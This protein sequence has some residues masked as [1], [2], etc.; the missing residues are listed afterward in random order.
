MTGNQDNLDACRYSS[1]APGAS[2]VCRFGKHTVTLDDQQRGEYVPNLKVSA[3]T[4]SG[5]TVGAEGSGTPVPVAAPRADS[6]PAVVPSLRQ[7]DAGHG[8]PWS[9]A[10]GTRVVSGPR[11]AATAR[12]FVEDL[13]TMTGR[14][15]PVV[16]EPARPGDIVLSAESPDPALGAEEYRLSIG[17]TVRIDA[18]TDTGAFYGT[19]TV[20]QMLKA[21]PLRRSL[22][23]GT[24]QD[25]PK[26]AT[27][28]QMLDVGRKFFPVSYLK[29]QIRQ[30]AWQKLNVFHLHFT[31]W[32][33]FRIQSDTF[34]GLTPKDGAY[35]K[36]DL[37]ALQDYAAK[38]HVEIVPEVDLPG[39][40]TPITSYDP[41]LR[42][43]CPS[44]D[45]AIWPGG[46]L[47][48]WTL[49]ITKPHTREFVKR[50]LDEIVPLFDS[51][52][53]H[54]GGDEIGYDDK[55]NAC[56]ELVQYA[57][58]RGFTYTG[59]VFVDFANELNATVR[60][61][62][63]TT[64]MWEWWNVYGQK[65]SISP[66]KNIIVDS[67]VSSD[68]SALAAQGYRVVATPENL[69]YVS[70]GFGQRLGQYGYVDVRKVYEDY[71]FPAP[72]GV[73]G[74]RVSRWS[75]KAEEQSPEWFDFY[76]KRPL[77]VLAERTWGGPRS[78][79]VWEFFARADAIG[80]P[81][82]TAGGELTAV[83]TNA[84]R[85]TTDSQETSQENGAAVNVLDS[86]PYTTWHTA[87][88]PTEVPM[89]HQLTMDLG[90]S[91]P[92]RAISY[93]PRQDG[94]VN[95]RIATYGVSV[96]ADGTTW[97][98][99][100]AGNFRDDA[101]EKKVTFPVTRARYVRFDATSAANGKPFA[102]AAELTVW[103]A[104]A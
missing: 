22:P 104:P 65:S 35:S 33:G 85:V 24:A 96:S 72:G 103:Q 45:E 101:T 4:P 1:L 90:T 43:S 61:H 46:E 75:D 80:G 18:Q 10:A 6:R 31:D 70:A 5:T 71:S 28:A 19:Q 62:G 83:P 25:A 36:A 98:Q 32:R 39:H 79:S 29:Q 13:E 34:P 57:K 3:T 50:L 63:K 87:Y 23:R 78:N 102:G 52:T 82:G 30:M 99:V 81:P 41:S 100:A 48:G 76:A 16:D 44:M 66:D 20:L 59:D 97:H 56:P 88:T 47:G 54:I 2:Y 55:K 14:R 69:L 58:D 12:T 89:P 94:G 91:Y 77:Q 84:V 7:W 60:S 49:D 68:P 53:F 95:G 64:E 74:Y 40:A 37:R 51:K 67:W 42:F 9:I 92:V 21:D 73:L 15:L 93:Q 26:L 17:D 38:Y 86:N 11:S 8:R 27:R